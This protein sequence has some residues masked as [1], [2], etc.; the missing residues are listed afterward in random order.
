V[1]GSR[2]EAEDVAQEALLRIFSKIRTFRTD[3]SFARWAY[4]IARN[5]AIARLRSRSREVPLEHAEEIAA[6]QRG[7]TARALRESLDTLPERLRE[8]VLMYYIDGYTGSEIGQS[9][10]VAAGTVRSRLTKAR[11][12]LRG[13]LMSM[14]RRELPEL[15]S[16]D[17]YK[18][19]VEWLRA[20]PQTEPEVVIEEVDAPLP[21]PDFTEGTWFFVPLNAG[22]T[23]FQAAYDHPERT[24]TN[25]HF[26]HVLG[27]AEIAG[28]ECWEVCIVDSE[29]L[30]SGQY[31]LWYWSVKPC[32]VRLVAKYFSEE[33][34]VTT[35][36]DPD[37]DDDFRDE[38]RFPARQPLVQRTGDDEFTDIHNLRFAPVGAYDVT[39]GGRKQ[40]C[41]RVID[42]SPERTLV[43]AYINTDGRTVLFRRYNAA[44]LWSTS[45]PGHWMQLGGVE[46]LAELGN[47]RIVFNGAEYYHWYDC[48]TD[49]AMQCALPL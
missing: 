44:P 41:L 1:L 31:M 32:S 16:G 10:G 11:R 39:I 38:P 46:R 42:A 25:T 14:V 29:G 37:G 33:D 36:N 48:V 35:W 23:A 28:E 49:S 5:A 18:A 2:D 8:T 9:L 47:H 17:D 19:L 45:K 4:V 12:M 34:R 40:R 13:E 27:K 20:F 15:I 26:T 21:D 30:D 43:D 22:G 6:P 3:G 7:D 24:L